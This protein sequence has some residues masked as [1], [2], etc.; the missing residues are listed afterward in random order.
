MNAVK[1]GEGAFKRDPAQ[2]IAEFAKFSL[3]QK[4][5]ARLGLA[6]LMRKNVMMTD[7][8]AEEIRGV[9]GNP[10][11]RDQ[12]GPLFK[13]KRQYDEFVEGV[14]W[15]HKMA[16]TA[17]ESLVGKVPEGE[18]SVNL[19]QKAASIAAS[20]AHFAKG[21]EWWGTMNAFRV[22][23]ETGMSARQAER[24][25]EEVAKQM[26]GPKPNIREF[27]RLTMP[28]VAPYA[29]AAVGANVPTM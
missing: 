20:V 26:F 29:G 7:F 23:R 24:M 17:R 25:S 19:A 5:F 14:M 13:S 18:K 11:M 12:L 15:E 1:W 2:N 28:N 16:D 4:E 27:P 22:L 21:S 8:S 9:L 3:A 10:W 6:N